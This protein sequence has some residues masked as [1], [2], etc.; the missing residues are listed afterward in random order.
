MHKVNAAI[1][2]VKLGSFYFA[3]VVFAIFERVGVWRSVTQSLLV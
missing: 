3:G 1:W 2:S